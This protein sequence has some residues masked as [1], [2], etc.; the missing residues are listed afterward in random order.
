MFSTDMKLFIWHP[1]VLFGILVLSV[2]FDGFVQLHPWRILKERQLCNIYLKILE[3]RSYI[4]HYCLGKA[5]QD[6]RYDI[7]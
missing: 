4:S 2:Q 5:N 7:D 3:I 1:V 6:T